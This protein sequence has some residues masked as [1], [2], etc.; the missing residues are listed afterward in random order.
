MIEEF[1]KMCKLGVPAE[2]KES[3]YALLLNHHNIFSLDKIDLAYFNTI[4]HKVFMK[5]EE[6]VYVKQLKIPDPHQAYLQGKV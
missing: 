3:Y 6:P 1:H 2:Y 4:L 5:S